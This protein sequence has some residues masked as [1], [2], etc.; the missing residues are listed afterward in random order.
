MGAADAVDDDEWFARGGVAAPRDM[1]VGTDQDEVA[2]VERPGVIVSDVDHVEGNAAP[3]GGVHQPVDVS[4]RPLGSG[5]RRCHGCAMDAGVP[6]ALPR[7]G[8]I[9]HSGIATTDGES[10][11]APS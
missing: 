4:P 1:L 9:R 2:L 11:Y 10:G 7:D 3:S 5:R 6:L 8:G